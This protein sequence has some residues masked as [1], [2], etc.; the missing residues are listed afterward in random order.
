MPKQGVMITVR[1]PLVLGQAPAA[2]SVVER[3]IGRP[4]AATGPRPPSPSR[5]YSR[6]SKAAAAKDGM[7]LSVPSTASA[8]ATLREA[9]VKARKGKT[10]WARARE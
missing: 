7:E 10:G 5:R 3:A 2:T 6:S 4:F 9:T 8:K 1:E